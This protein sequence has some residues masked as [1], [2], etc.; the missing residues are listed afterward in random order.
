M[1]D[2]ISKKARSLNMSRVRSKNTGIELQVRRKLHSLGYRFRLNSK[3]PGRPDI[4]LPKYKTVIFVHGC[5]WHQHSCSKAKLPE[6]NK[7]FWR[8]KLKKNKQ[9]DKEVIQKLKRLGWTV[10]T[11]WECELKNKNGFERI[12]RLIKQAN[13]EPVLKLTGTDS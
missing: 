10:V 8:A 12:M 11:I 7:E 6:T 3:L 9:R 2:R 1:A 5:F 13:S 4:T